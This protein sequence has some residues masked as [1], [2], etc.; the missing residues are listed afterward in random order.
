MRVMPRTET[1]QLMV[2]LH[3]FQA[4]IGLWRALQ[5]AAAKRLATPTL[6][7]LLGAGGGPALGALGLGL[8]SLVALR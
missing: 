5:T 7:A 6:D 1:L 3:A 2:T 8:C 4:A